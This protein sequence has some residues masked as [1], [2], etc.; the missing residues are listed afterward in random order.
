MRFS[1]VAL[2]VPFRW[3]RLLLVLCCL[4]LMPVGAAF[5]QQTSCARL[6]RD[7]RVLQDATQVPRAD[8]LRRQAQRSS[9][10]ALKIAQDMD[11]IGCKNTRFLLWGN[12]PPAQCPAMQT[13]VDQLSQRVNA[14]LAQAEQAPS[15]DSRQRRLTQ[16]TAAYESSGCTSAPQPVNDN[17]TPLPQIDGINPQPRDDSRPV[18][19]IADTAA[20]ERANAY[21]SGA[22]APGA[23]C[24][25]LCDGYFFPLSGARSRAQ[26]GEMCQ[27]QC[28]ATETSVYFKRD[29]SIATAF[30]V[31]GRNYSSLPNAFA[32]QKSF[33]PECSCRQSG[34]SWSQ[35]LQRAE[36]LVSARGKPD[37][38]V[39]AK[40]A[41]QWSL[42]QKSMLVKGKKGKTE[43]LTVAV[44][45]PPTQDAVQDQAVTGA[46]EPQPAPGS[47]P[48]P[49]GSV[50]QQIDPVPSEE[51]PM[52]PALSDA[53]PA[54]SDTMVQIIETLP[55]PD[56]APAQ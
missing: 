13:R 4:G 35:A 55:T 14:L 23:V 36:T 39:D 29:S 24:V 44:E 47:E 21:A 48:D 31:E 7:M 32:F 2:I 22:G 43:P 46:A 50:I 54:E 49:L 6:A 19:P 34:E 30:S 56:G 42:V 1:P 53:L 3:L 17:S 5:S 33:N 10:Q 41:A 9:A 37:L 27:A 52:P 12:D 25:R 11:H 20:E 38:L 40:V 28:P 16:L 15:A 45:P 18:Q 8:Q 51:Q 26:A